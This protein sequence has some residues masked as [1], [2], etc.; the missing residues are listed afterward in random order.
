M[1]LNADPSIK[2]TRRRRL[3]LPSKPEARMASLGGFV[4]QHV[5]FVRRKWCRVAAIA[6]AIGIGG[7]AHAADLALNPYRFYL[8]Y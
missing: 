6:L 4:M 2:P 7:L 8:V 5:P 1:P 3:V